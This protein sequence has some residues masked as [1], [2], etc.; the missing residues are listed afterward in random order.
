MTSCHYSI[1]NHIMQNPIKLALYF[2]LCHWGQAV[3]WFVVALTIAETQQEHLTQLT[4]TPTFTLPQK[5]RVNI[6]KEKEKHVC[7]VCV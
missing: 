3:V 5:R 4:T 7:C 2:I 1:C 6:K